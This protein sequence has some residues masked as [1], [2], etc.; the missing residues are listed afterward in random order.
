MPPGFAPGG[1]L[2]YAFRIVF[3]RTNWHLSTNP[4]MK[5]QD[6]NDARY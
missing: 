4:V 5:A 1:I 3:A 2:L 6:E